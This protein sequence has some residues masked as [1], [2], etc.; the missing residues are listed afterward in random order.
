MNDLRSWRVPLPQT[1]VK[2]AATV[3]LA[4]LAVL[5]TGDPQLVFLAGIAALGAGALALRDLLAPVRLT[6]DA[7]GL[8]VVSGYAGKRRVPWP[9]VTA[10]RVDERQRL[11]M[12]TRLL[13]IE[14]R[15]DLHLLSTFDLGEDVRDVEAE[16]LRLSARD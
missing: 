6:A 10:V 14:T 11:L 15:D 5:S 16:L 12:R 1:A 4:A 8:T 7:E 2:C 9:D 13:E 3:V